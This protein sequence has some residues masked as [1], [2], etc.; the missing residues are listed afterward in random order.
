MPNQRAVGQK[1]LTVPCDEK[2]IAMIDDNLGVCRYSN[3]SQFVRDAIKEKLEGYGITV[4]AELTLSPDRKGKGGPTKYP[5]HRPSYFVM[6]EKPS[7]GKTGATAQSLRRKQN[8][9]KTHH[10]KS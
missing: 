9:A 3:R 10:S 7:S 1:L 2:F 4:P 5:E 8:A 6:N